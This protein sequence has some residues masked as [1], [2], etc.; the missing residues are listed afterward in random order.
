MYLSISRQV[1]AK[2]ICMYVFLL[3]LVVVNVLVAASAFIVF[4]FLLHPSGTGLNWHI[5]NY[6]HYSDGN[7]RK[8]PV[9]V[10]RCELTYLFNNLHGGNR[11]KYYK[12]QII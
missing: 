11:E 2:Y 10:K 6:I 12:Y 7:C 4:Q 3:F 1:T 9:S 5:P 8:L